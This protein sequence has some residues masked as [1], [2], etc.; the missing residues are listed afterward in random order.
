MAAG[1]TVAIVEM[2]VVVVVVVVVE[3]VVIFANRIHRE[4]LVDLS[5]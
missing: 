5:K 2:V 1:I 4:F 3:M